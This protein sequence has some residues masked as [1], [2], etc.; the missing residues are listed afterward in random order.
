MEERRTARPLRTSDALTLGVWVMGLAPGIPCPCCGTAMR[1]RVGRLPGR[2]PSG[3]TSLLGSLT[4]GAWVLECPEC[5]CE[6]EDEEGSTGV[7]EA[8]CLCS[9]A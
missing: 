9:A 2:R 6:I 5:G 7:S 3:S 1:E 8:A 4:R